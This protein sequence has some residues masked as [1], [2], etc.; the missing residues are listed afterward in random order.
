[1][2]LLLFYI[3]ANP[4]I[5]QSQEQREIAILLREQTVAWNKG[6]IEKFMIGYWNNDS[7]MFIGRNGVTYGYQHTLANYKR[8]YPNAEEMGK[9]SFDILQVKKLSKEYYFVLGKWFLKRIAGNVEGHYTLLF[10]KIK[11]RWQIVCDH[12]S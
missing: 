4:V 10:R 1:M 9:L 12:S 3:A 6:D 7:L 11:G 5:S 2:S 8:N